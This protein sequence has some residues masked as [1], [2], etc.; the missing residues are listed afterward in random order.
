MLSSK[1]NISMKSIKIIASLIIICVALFSCNKESL[2]EGYSRGPIIKD[3]KTTVSFN[4]VG[5]TII[6]LNVDD[7]TQT[8]TFKTS[9]YKGLTGSNW[10]ATDSLR[11]SDLT[12]SYANTTEGF[13]LYKFNNCISNFTV[14]SNIYGDFTQFNYAVMCMSKASTPYTS[15]YTSITGTING[16]PYPLSTTFTPSFLLGKDG[17]IAFNYFTTVD[18][19]KVNYYGW[20][21]VIINQNDIYF[22]NYSYSKSK[23]IVIGALK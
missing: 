23:D 6:N 18:N 7:K 2:I 13:L 11:I 15:P 1:K 17:Y 19:L 16:S 9:K 3:I 22:D 14:G 8:I 10:I 20:I 21:H 5:N 4:S 12:G